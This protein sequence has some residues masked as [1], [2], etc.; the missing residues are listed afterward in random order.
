MFFDPNQIGVPSDQGHS[1]MVENDGGLT[2]KV[3]QVMKSEI[4]QIKER[5][6]KGIKNPIMIM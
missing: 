5:G 1:E 6:E 4:E 3:W 2:Y